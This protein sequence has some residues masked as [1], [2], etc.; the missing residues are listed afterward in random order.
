MS[1]SHDKIFLSKVSVKERE[2]INCFAPIGIARG[3]K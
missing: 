1:F 3:F 2:T